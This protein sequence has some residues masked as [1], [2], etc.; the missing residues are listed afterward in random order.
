[1]S[2]TAQESVAKV[3]ASLL[4]SR[5]EAAQFGIDANA[6][7]K[8]LAWRIGWTGERLSVGIDPTDMELLEM[9]ADDDAALA[10]TPHV[11]EEGT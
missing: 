9:L 4:A 11:E 6:E 8:D 10:A 2:D 5:E 1:M 7:A 3:R